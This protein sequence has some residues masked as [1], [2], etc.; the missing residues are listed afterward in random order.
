M[1]SFEEAAELL[2]G[3]FV[4]GA[5]AGFEVGDELVFDVEAR[6]VDD[7][8]VFVALFP[9]LAL[10]EFHWV[11]RAVRGLGNLWGFW[12]RMDGMGRI[13]ENRGFIQT[14]LFILVRFLC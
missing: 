1:G 5:F 14:I 11:V 9:E 7:A 10:L 12:T 4:E 2:F 8:D 3:E 6:P 13:L